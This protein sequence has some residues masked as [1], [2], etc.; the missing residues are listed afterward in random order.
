MNEVPVARLRELLHYNPESGVLTW[1]RTVNSRAVKGAEAGNRDPSG[2]IKLRVDGALLRAHRVAWAIHHGE[3]PEDEVDHID[4]VRHNNRIAN[5]R[6]G[7]RAANT[8]NYSHVSLNSETM[9]RGVRYI[10]DGRPAPWRVEL[11]FNRR[12][13][14][15]AFDNLLDAAAFA[16]STRNRLWPN[17]APEPSPRLAGPSANA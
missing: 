3:W 10:D 7:G 13:I 1:R 6:V 17:S 4:R 9:A 5:L 15:S 11:K 16:V 8:H 12:P 14:R 2:Y